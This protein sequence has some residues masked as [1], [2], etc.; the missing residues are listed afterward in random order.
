MRATLVLPTSA[1]EA[2]QPLEAYLSRADT[3]NLA[4]RQAAQTR[5]KA[6]LGVKTARQQ[7]LPDVSLT[8]NYLR[9]QGSPVLPHNSVLVG[10]LLNWNIYDFGERKAVVQQ[11]ESQQRQARENELYTK[12]EV[13]GA[14]QKA[15]RQLRQA[16]ALTAA[17][18][19]A[20]DLRAA[21]LK[22]KQDALAAGK[23]LPVEVLTT[24]A[25]LAK[26]KADL[27]AAQLNYRLVLTELAH[28]SGQR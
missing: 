6:A 12:D 10:G 27:L 26:A 25:T 23:V 5:E 15:Y 18:Q 14:V 17:A 8:A 16:A 1:E 20:T 11:R 4:N 21:E 22:V 7:Y 9:I 28:A 2:P 13:A 3:A 24:Q 19:K